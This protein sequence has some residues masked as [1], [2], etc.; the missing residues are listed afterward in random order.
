MKASAR[1]SV[2]ASSVLLTACL[3]LTANAGAQAST[4]APPGPIEFDPPV[5]YP[6]ATVTPGGSASPIAHADFNRDGLP[7]LV[8][9][10]TVGAGPV[11]LLGT[12]D[13]RFADAVPVRS[14]SDA[15][16]VD[17]GDFNRD[18]NPDIV[19]GSYVTSRMTVLLGDGRGGFR[20]TGSFPLG[21]IPTQFAIADYNSDGNQDVVS[22]MY[23]GGK[24]SLL[25]GKGD[26]TFGPTKAVAASISSL[27]IVAVDLNKD[28]AVD[29][30]VTETVPNRILRSLLPGELNILMGN[31]DGTFK[32][33]QTYAVG[34]M[35]EDFAVGDVDEDGNVDLVVANALS[36]DLSIM[37]GKGDGS[38]HQEERIGSGPRGLISLP[39]LEVEAAPGVKLADFNG[40]HHLDLAAIQTVTNRVAISLGD[41][42]GNFRLST[43][44]YPAP[45][46]PEAFLA[47]D[48]NLDKC[49]DLVIPG[50]LPQ[51]LATKDI[52]KTRVF[53][54]V[55][56]SC[57][58]T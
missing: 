39:F 37:R 3:A 42:K 14:G 31:G 46:F 28:G 17:T 58:R 25:L 55:N 23:V 33:R 11:L 52:L 35:P 27:A 44:I 41:G 16:V 45:E 38:L 21:G 6:A 47:V 8:A 54:H 10:N 7:D 53:V 24:V 49:P 36:N 32:P 57:S 9:A 20:S 56:R 50:N 18:G 5:A 2:R 48:V 19:T 1:A 29:L 12:G 30:A 4:V 13:G 51:L 40:D 43:I 22:S 26:G 15:S 34:L